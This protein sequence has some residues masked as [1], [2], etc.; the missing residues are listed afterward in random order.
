MGGGELEDAIDQG[1]IG[2]N[3]CKT[4]SLGGQA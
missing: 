1:S 4:R 2:R 3:V